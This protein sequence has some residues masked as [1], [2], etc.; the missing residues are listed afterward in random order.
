MLSKFEGKPW[1]LGSA[2]FGGVCFYK[3]NEQHLSQLKICFP[4]I[5]REGEKKMRTESLTPNQ[6]LHTSV[7]YGIRV[8]IIDRAASLLPS[9]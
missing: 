9:D 6:C 8:V 3:K 2:N 1:C 7:Y 5:R 4:R